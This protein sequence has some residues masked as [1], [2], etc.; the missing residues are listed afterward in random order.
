MNVLYVGDVMGEVGMQVVEKVLPSL[1]AE[2]Q[3][4]V[5]IAQA[6]NERHRPRASFPPARKRAEE[7]LVADRSPSRIEID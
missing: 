7:E 4:D 2:K 3:I 5:V 6:E 1:R